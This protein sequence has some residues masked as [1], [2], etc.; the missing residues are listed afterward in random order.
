MWQ[1]QP[2]HPKAGSEGSS[3][4]LMKAHECCYNLSFCYCW[5]KQIILFIF[6]KYCLWTIFLLHHYYWCGK[7]L[8]NN[9]LEKKLMNLNTVAEAFPIFL[10]E[11]EFQEETRPA[12]VISAWKSSKKKNC[13]Y[14]ISAS[15]ITVKGTALTLSRKRVAALIGAGCAY[16]WIL[17]TALGACLE[18]LVLE[19]VSWWC[20]LLRKCIAMLCLPDYWFSQP[21]NYDSAILACLGRVLLLGAYFVVTFK[22][23]NS[24]CT[25]TWDF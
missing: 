15:H 6:N 5:R 19:P 12:Q 7:K 8:V 25:S 14:W 16:G 1:H 24:E 11:S 23:Q 2:H 21:L 17:E 18:E 10:A 13:I 3:Y 22:W 9:T 4:V 20:L